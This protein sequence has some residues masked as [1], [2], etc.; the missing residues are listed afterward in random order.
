[1]SANS[2]NWK[3][4]VSGLNKG[5]ARHAL[6]KAVFFY[7]LGEFRD[8]TFEQ[9]RYRAS[10]LNLLTAAIVLW[11]TVYLERATSTST[12]T[13]PST[14]TCYN[15]SH[16]SAGNTSTS[17]AT[18]PGKPAATQTPA[19]TRP[20]DQSQILNVLCGPFSHGPRPRP[21]RHQSRPTRTTRSA[22]SMP[23]RRHARRNQTRP[24][25]TI[26]TR[27]TEHR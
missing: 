8:R 25:R 19:N 16:L 5:E 17:P 22:R 26:A 11:N 2:N 24:A 18:T 14:P 9:Q 20:Y 12:P 27:R 15:T 21:H 4:S 10:G 23:G 3:S 1:M 6:A 13:S 7:R